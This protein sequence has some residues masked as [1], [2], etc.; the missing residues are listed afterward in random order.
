MRL[1]EAIIQANQRALA[2]DSSAGVHVADY[3]DELP[4]VA[5]TCIDPR[6]SKL[7]PGALGL[8]DDNFI[9]LRNAGNILT[10]PLS[11]TMRS[12]AMAC[13]IK[14]GRE[15]AVIGH[16][17][18]KVSQTSSS[19]LIECF[20]TLGVP[21][22][23]LPDNIADYFGLFSGIRQNVIHGVEVIRS[24]PLIGV[25]VVIQ[26][27]VID[28][29]T[30]ALDW[31]VNGYEMP[32]RVTV[33][34]PGMAFPTLDAMIGSL[35]SNRP[36]QMGEKIGEEVQKVIKA[37]EQTIAAK[38]PAIVSAPVKPAAASPAPPPILP[39]PQRPRPIPLPPPIRID[40]RKRG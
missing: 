24:S 30:G 36:F 11:S 26:G 22:E 34:A 2:G 37:A 5:L 19:S 3:A 33:P 16:T 25:N 39:P 32:A 7:L 1:F 28:I 23:K 17:D 8:T 9:W 12:I 21:R 15:I 18:C 14:G 35:A 10:G 6:L 38:A 4:V 29:R 20:K 27:L 40:P 13:A 31:V